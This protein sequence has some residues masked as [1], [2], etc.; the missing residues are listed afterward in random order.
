MSIRLDRPAWIAALVAVLWVGVLVNGSDRIG[1]PRDESFYVVA[2]DFAASWYV[3]LFDPE[4]SALSKAHIERRDRFG[5][6]WEHPVLMK[7]LFGLSKHL[8][9]DQWGIISS[10]LL[11]YRL[12]TMLFAGIGIFLVFLLG[13]H[14]FS[15]GGTPGS[16]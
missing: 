5:W 7:S 2:A 16:S 13:L 3:D 8:L 15:F 9:H 6:N 14:S 12:P 1:V 11:A 10:P 4:V